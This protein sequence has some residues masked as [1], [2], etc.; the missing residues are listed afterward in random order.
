MQML[1]ANHI[2]E[3]D[4]NWSVTYSKRKS[5]DLAEKLWTPAKMQGNTQYDITMELTSCLILFDRATFIEK[6]I[7]QLKL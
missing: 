7:F 1:S 2:E 4:V 6:N 3:I 5:F